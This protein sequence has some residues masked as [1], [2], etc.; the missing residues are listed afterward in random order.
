MLQVESF[1]QEGKVFA[2]RDAN[3]GIT[4][5]SAV[6]P[7]NKIKSE[8]RDGDEVTLKIGDEDIL[9]KSVVTLSPGRYVGTVFGFE[10]SYSVEFGGIQIGD[11]VEFDEMHVFGCHER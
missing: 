2:N 9:I 7:G 4:F 11:N 3:V 5:F 6:T 8:I 1:A 10:P